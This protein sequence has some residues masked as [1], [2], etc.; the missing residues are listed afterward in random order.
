MSHSLQ[1][2]SCWPAE[3]LLGLEQLNFSKDVKQPPS[4]RPPAA[5]KG[6]THLAASFR[7]S[8]SNSAAAAIALSTSHALERGQYERAAKLAEHAM[9]FGDTRAHLVG[10]RVALARV[11]HAQ[12]KIVE[13]QNMFDA[14]VKD[15]AQTNLVAFVG[16]GQ[17]Q[18]ENGEFLRIDV[19]GGGGGG[20][21]VRLH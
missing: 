13:A 18:I 15:S 16:L 12:G 19:G 20:N 21:Q 4:S 11:Y 10:G 17:T 7:G 6:L 8:S 14:A 2:P 9:Q 3:L 5:I 1:N